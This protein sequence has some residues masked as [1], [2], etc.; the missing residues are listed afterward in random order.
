M[1][2]TITLYFFLIILNF[3]FAKN[4]TVSVNPIMG[5]WK[6]TAQSSTNDFQQVLNACSKDYCT[7][8][9]VFGDHNKFSH[10]FVNDK[11]IVVKTLTGKWKTDGDQLDV[12]Y[13]DIKYSMHVQYFYLDKDLVLGQNFNHA[14]FTKGNIMVKNPLDIAITS[15][16]IIIL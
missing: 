15:D 5:S 7:E 2:Q 9:F 10:Q 8:F 1:K 4:T 11:G 13:S 6:Y 3:S 16:A 12:K 14:I